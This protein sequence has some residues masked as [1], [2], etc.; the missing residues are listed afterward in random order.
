MVFARP[1]RNPF[2][3][4]GA[5]GAHGQQEVAP[6]KAP[7]AL[8]HDCLLVLIVLAAKYA[9]DS[10]AFQMRQAQARRSFLR[11]GRPARRNGLS[12]TPLLHC[13]MAPLPAGSSD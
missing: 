9:P 8:G 3:R 1:A 10:R 6:G 4:R 5:A 7:G 12:P 13:T 11:S 2:A